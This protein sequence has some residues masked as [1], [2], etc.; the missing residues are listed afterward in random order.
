MRFLLGLVLA[1]AVS[2]CSD[3]SFTPVL[4]EALE[5]GAPRPILV[6]TTRMPEPDGS[7]GSRRSRQ[8]RLL[9]LVV[10]IPPTHKPGRSEFGY[11]NPDPASQFTLAGQRELASEQA[12]R[13]R[14]RQ[15]LRA[16]PPGRRDVTVFVHGYNATQAETV[17]RAAQIA[18]DFAMPGAQ[19]VYSWPSR[20]TAS[21][22]AYDNDSMLFA[23]DG[24]ERLLNL[25][26]TANPDH[27]V[28]VGHSMGALLTMETLRQADIRNP[29]WSVRTLDGL[30]LISPDLDVEVFAS[31]MRA[32]SP[33]PRPIVIAVSEIDPVLNLSGLLRG[34]ANRERLGNISSISKVDDLPVTIIDLTDFTTSSGSPHFTVATSPALITVFR[35]ADSVVRTM[36]TDRFVLDNVL[37]GTVIHQRNATEIRLD[38][39]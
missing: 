19:V 17:F 28:V 34:T 33:P 16:E 27:I 21:G 6:A 5:V 3:R 25:I 10:S 30:M 4:P 12:F 20:G 35:E 36:G 9:D 24:L 23:R 31:Q 38:R 14:L 15:Q 18:N 1:L 29:G 7:F 8:L 22:Y 26:H 11:A 32:L 13:K 37:P 2:A 39:K